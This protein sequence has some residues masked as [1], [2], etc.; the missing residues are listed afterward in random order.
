MRGRARRSTKPHWVG[1]L[2]AVGED[3]EIVDV[4]ARLD[5]LDLASTLGLE[6]LPLGASEVVQALRTEGGLSSV[7]A[8]FARIELLRALRMRQLLDS[9]GQQGPSDEAPIFIV[10]AGRSGTSALFQLLAHWRDIRAPTTWEL[11]M[12]Q[13]IGR[14][15]YGRSEN[16]ATRQDS[17]WEAAAPA[18]ALLHENRGD[19]P[20]ECLPILAAAFTDHHWT[21]CYRLSSVRARSAECDGGEAYRL[22]LGA[23]S[24]IRFHR[25]QRRHLFKSPTHGGHIE[26]LLSAYPNAMILYLIRDVTATFRSW[27]S[28]Y[29]AVRNMRTTSEWDSIDATDAATDIRCS[30]SAIAS[31]IDS[32]LLHPGNCR[33]VSYHEVATDIASVEKRLRPWIEGTTLAPRERQAGA[34]GTGEAR[35]VPE[36]CVEVHARLVETG[37]R[38]GMFL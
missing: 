27:R 13:R 1:A 11:M 36:D 23:S 22:H 8:I 37:D 10:G 35:E 28:F 6:V 33:L 30:H 4:V 20:S 3:F 2:N 34:S 25:Q 16:L 24:L 32:G 19:L 26:S 38:N 12:P 9:I 29:R 7:G 18:F 17:L 15:D 31:A 14:P 21:G 5:L